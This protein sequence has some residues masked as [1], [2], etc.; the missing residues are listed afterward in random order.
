MTSPHFDEF[1]SSNM[2]QVKKKFVSIH[3][4]FNI[5]FDVMM[6]IHILSV[7]RN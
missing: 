2:E 7:L 5:K 1:N 6:I 3:L 4:F